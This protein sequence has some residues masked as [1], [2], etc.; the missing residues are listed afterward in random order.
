M[1]S[2]LHRS[3]T[4]ARSLILAAVV[5]SLAGSEALAQRA[6]RTRGAGR[7]RATSSAFGRN[8]FNQGGGF[9]SPG[10]Y[11]SGYG[12]PATGYGYGFADPYGVAGGGTYSP[13]VADP[14]GV[15]G[16]AAPGVADPYGVFGGGAYSPMA[17]DPYGVCGGS[18]SIFGYLFP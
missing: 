13:G 9:W 11:Y 1:N 16:G 6:G 5:L 17:A 12:Y 7:G 4:V 18:A 10:F 2:P 14:Y 3:A 15:F 8:G